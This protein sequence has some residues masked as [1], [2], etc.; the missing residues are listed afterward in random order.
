LRKIP[1]YVLAVIVVLV[2]VVILGGAWV[3]QTGPVAQTSATSTATSVSSSTPESPTVEFTLTVQDTN[4]PFAFVYNSQNN[5]TLQVHKGDTV[6][7]TLTNTGT[8][9]HDFTLEGYNIKTSVLN[10]GQSDSI[11]FKADTTGTFTYYC[12]VPGHKDLGMQGQL[13]VQ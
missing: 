13:I 12:S 3:L 4:T 2:V 10:P 7:V 9:R 5:P 6:K 11:V 8:L 1:N